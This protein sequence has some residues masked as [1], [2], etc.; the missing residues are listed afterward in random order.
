MK[1]LMSIEVGQ[2]FW[3]GASAHL[4]HLF[5]SKSAPRSVSVVGFT[6]SKL[7][8][9]SDPCPSVRVRTAGTAARPRG[10]GSYRAELIALPIGPGL[11]GCSCRH[12]RGEGLHLR[13]Q[14]QNGLSG[15]VSA[16]VLVTPLRATSVAAANS[17]LD[18]SHNGHHF[19][20]CYATERERPAFW[21][22]PMSRATI[23]DRFSR[24]AGKS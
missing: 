8:F 15:W 10:T 24:E 4:R 22:E 2:L 9:F 16:C 6:S 11:L 14:L 1:D 23:G 7:F 5:D 20:C 13:V 3:Q 21:A 19:S 18:V 17:Y 12:R